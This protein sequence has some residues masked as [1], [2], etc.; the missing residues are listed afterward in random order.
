MSGRRIYLCAVGDPMAEE[1][2][3]LQAELGRIFG[4]TV[5]LARPGVFP[6]PA[7]AFSP[8]RQ[9]YHSTSILQKLAKVVSSKQRPLLAV[10]GVDLYAEG[11]N[12]V[13]GEA[14]P[15]A[16]LAIISTF[17]LHWGLMG[18][19]VEDQVYRERVVKEA[20][21]ELGH[22][23]GL[24]HCSNPRCVMFFSNSLADTDR[25]GKEFCP[26]CRARLSPR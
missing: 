26:R 25:K 17:R 4:A 21:H 15:A 8:R 2:R 3:L 23:F 18:G 24:G 9:Q 20:V 14:D 16:E 12:F 13:F 19:E 11:L 10:T 6:I 1:L 7:S 22:V 5:E